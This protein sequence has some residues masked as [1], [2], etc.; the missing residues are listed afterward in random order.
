MR[1]SSDA[2][3]AARQRAQELWA[4][5]PLR[6]LRQMFVLFAQGVYKTA[7]AGCFRWLDDEEATE[8]LI[9][10]ETPVDL[11]VVG[12][13]PTIAITRG[14][15]RYSEISIGGR[16]S[17]SMVGMTRNLTDLV[18]TTISLNH[19]AGN[20]LES[21]QLAMITA[22][23]IVALPRIFTRGTPV[24]KVGAP[25]VSAPS[26]AGALVAGDRTGKWRNTSV[27]VPVFLQEYMQVRRGQRVILQHIQLGISTMSRPAT[28]TPTHGQQVTDTI[29]T[30][31]VSEVWVSEDGIK[32]R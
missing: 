17:D 20:D 11:S 27:T 28:F 19:L 25:G 6:A 32:T 14:Q 16:Q 26:P 21:E 31:P 8:I 13:K 22:R 18:P 4:E 15:L 9:T 30:Q 12:V 29:R 1:P 7:P 3:S 5:Q 10:D 24:H 2:V 23:H